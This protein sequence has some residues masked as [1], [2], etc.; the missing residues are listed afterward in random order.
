MTPNHNRYDSKVK[1]KIVDQM[2]IHNSQL[3]YIYLRIYRDENCN[4]SQSQ[5]HL[6]VNDSAETSPTF[7][8]GV[9]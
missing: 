4:A 1:G 7:D 3:I 6:L 5:S 2:R 8:F 9:K